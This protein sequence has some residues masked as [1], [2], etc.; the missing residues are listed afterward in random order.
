MKLTKNK[1][2]NLAILKVAEGLG[3]VLIPYSAGSIPLI[4]WPELHSHCSFDSTFDVW[5]IGLL[6]GLL[7]FVFSV[8]AWVVIRLNL[9]WA[10]NLKRDK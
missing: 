4:M 3:I 1:W 9:D 10:K 8:A 7:F 5:A 2:V 6:F